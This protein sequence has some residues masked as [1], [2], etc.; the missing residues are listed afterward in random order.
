[1]SWHYTPYALLMLLAAVASLLLAFYAWRRRGTPGATML[2]LMM[3]AGATWSTAYGL[4][5]VSVGVAAKF[6]WANL[7][8]LG[9]VTV[10][11]FWMLFALLYTGRGRWVTRRA[12]ALLA[13]VPAISLALIWT[14]GAHRLFWSFRE[15]D[16]SGPFSA[17]GAVYGP[18]F[19]VHTAYCYLLILVAT[20]LLVRALVSPLRLY[21]GQRVALLIG[22][23]VPWASN[24]ASLYGL[25]PVPNLDPTPLA[26]TVTG[27][28]LSWSLLRYRFLD[29]LP[30]ARDVAVDAMQDGVIVLDAQNRVVDLNLTAQRVL[31]RTV[32]QA[33][34]GSL[35][36]IAPDLAEFL[37]RCPDAGRVSEEMGLGT[38][39]ARRHYDLTLSPLRDGSGWQAG[40]LM[41]LRD[42]TEQKRA[43]EALK[44]SEERH[45]GVLE[46]M[47]EGYFEVDLAGNLVFFNDSVCRILGYPRGE[48]IG[49]NHRDF[50]D[51]ESA[52][53]V[54]RH[55]N[56]VYRTGESVKGFDWELT[57][58]DGGR[59]YV[60]TSVS[61]RKS[62]EGEPVGFKGVIRDVSE[63]KKAETARRKS[64]ER[65]RSLVQNASDLITVVDQTGTITYESPSKERILGYGPQELVGRP[66]LEHV[67]PDDLAQVSAEF[68]SV[69]SS[70][71][72]LSEEPAE[73]WYRHA[74]GTWRYLEALAA[75]LLDDPSVGSIV[76][77]SRDVTERK[78]AEEDLKDSEERFRS[79]VQNASDIISILNPDG[80]IRY[81][82]PSVEWVLGHQP[83]ERVGR[84]AFGDET[85]PD[86]IESTRDA[87]ARGLERP[88]STSPPMGFRVRH[89]DGSWRHLEAVATNRLDH[90]AVGGIVV[91]ARD[92][93]ERKA[94]E[95]R[96][97]HQ[98]LHDG[99]TGLPNRALFLDRLSQ[100]LTRQQGRDDE[101]G[102]K[103]VA[104]LFLDLDNFKY[105]NDS[106]GHEI[107]DRMLVEAA[108]RLEGAL[109][110]P[111]TAARIGGDEFCI[112]LTEVEE[113]EEA[114][115][116]AQRV[117]EAL[118]APFVLGGREAFVPGDGLGRLERAGVERRPGQHRQRGPRQRLRVAERVEHGRTVGPVERHQPRRPV[119]GARPEHRD[120]L[121]R[122]R[123]HLRLRPG[124]RVVEGGGHDG[125][126]RPVGVGD[127]LE[128]E[129]DLLAR[130]GADGVG[131]AEVLE[132]PP[133][134]HAADA[135]EREQGEGER[136]HGGGSGRGRYESRRGRGETGSRT[137]RSGP[138]QT[139]TAFAP[140]LTRTPMPMPRP[141]RLLFVAEP[142]AAVQALASTRAGGPVQAQLAPTAD[143]LRAALAPD[144]VMAWDA[145]VFVP[146]GPVEEVE[147]AVFVPD[148][149]ALFVVGGEVPLLLSE[150]AAEAVDAAGLAGLH[151]RLAAPE[152]AVDVAPAHA[153]PAHAE[154]AHAEP[155]HAEPAHAEPAHAEPAHAGP[156][157]V[158]TPGPHSDGASGDGASGSDA[159]AV[160]VPHAPSG[161]V[162][163]DGMAGPPP[164]LAAAPPDAV[165]PETDAPAGPGAGAPDPAPRLA[166]LVDHLTV[167]LYQSG[168]DGRISYANPALA[169]IL[170]AD[171]VAALAGLDV[172][173]DLGY[174][175][176]AFVREI[177]AT[178]AVRNLVVSWVRVTGERVHTRENARAIRDDDGGL[179]YYEGTME[180]VTAEVEAQREEQAVAQQHRAAATFAAVAAE[181]TDP[182]S[183]HQA[184]AE[185]LLDATG[186]EW[187]CL[188]V[189]DGDQNRVAATAGHPPDGFAQ[190]FMASP[191]LVRHAVPSRAV[192][193]GSLSDL[194]APADVRD[195]LAEM[196]VEAAALVPVYRS[197]T[198]LGLLAWGGGRRASAADVRAAEALAWQLGG[199]LDRARAVGELRD[200]EATLS[201]IAERTPHV[202]YRLRIDPDGTAYDYLSPA[203][204]TLTGY[205]RADLDAKGGI[206]G[207]V[208]RSV[209]LE[210]EALSGLPASSDHYQARYLMATAHGPRWVED[211][212]HPWLDPSGRPVGF[213]GV[214]QDVTERKAREDR[215]ADEAQAA[216]DRQ[217]ALVD[218]SHLDGADAFGGPAAAVAAAT[219]GASDVSF[220]VC[221]PGG[222]CRALYAPPPADPSAL[223]AASLTTAARHVGEHRAL[224]ISDTASDPRL[225]DLDLGPVVR[226]FGLRSLLVAPVRRDGGV[227]GVVVV[228]HDQPHDWDAAEAEFSA[229]VADSVALALEREDRE[230]AVAAL[231][232]SQQRY[233]VLAEMTSD[234]AFA[235]VERDGRSEGVAWA[236]GACARITG[237]TLNE[238]RAPGAIVGLIHPGSTDA[239]RE[240]A[241]RWRETGEARGE[242]QIVAQS[243][244]PRWVD[245]HVRVGEPTG[246]GAVV[247]YHSGQDV[248]E[249]KAAEAALVDAREAAETGREAAE[250]MN[251]LKSSFLAN[252][253]HEIRT[254]LTGILGFADL[255]A[256]EVD[257]DQRAFVGYIERNGRRLLDTLNAVLDLSQ[258]EAGEFHAAR[259]PVPLAPAVVEAAEA[260]R[261]E[262][263]EKGVRFD[264]EADPDVVADVDPVALARVAGHLVSNA[265]KFTDA[266]GVVVSVAASGDGRAVVRVA[267]TGVGISP[268]FLP[269]AFEA[270][271]QEAT[272]HDR[273]HEGSG[274]GLT[275]VDRLVAL[276]G[277]EVAVES[278]RPGGTVVTVS[279]PRVAGSPEAPAPAPDAG[280]A[281]PSAALLG[282][283]FD[284]TFLSAPA[285]PAPSPPARPAAP[286]PPPAPTDMFDFRFGRSTPSDPSP[287]AD[288]ETPS[289]PAPAPTFAAPPAPRPPAPAAPPPVAPVASAPVAPA[290]T[291]PTPPAPTADPV[292]IVRARPDTPAPTIPQA[293]PPELAEVVDGPSDA[294]PP[295]LVVED[296]DDTRMLL[297]R[298]LRSAYDVTAVGDARSALLAMNERRFAGLVLDINL[299]GK[300]TGADVLRIARSLPDYG[301]VFAIALTAYALPG[302]RE[303]L[304]ESGFNEYISKP[305]S[306]QSLMETLAAGVHA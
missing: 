161:S 133:G 17:V 55:F 278:D 63:R 202:L 60:E 120:R 31:V 74:E 23:L 42:V 49:M 14:N 78:L 218:L 189:R 282:D 70:P 257:G 107:G 180:D 19:W 233:R 259:R 276:L 18:W 56:R 54:Y 13:V 143:A 222:P 12:L 36:G 264:V 135:V 281:R 148:G 249:R 192:S 24:A 164:A 71:G 85:H 306:R 203:I 58:K 101:D 51:Q 261:A 109:R 68:I 3:V 81:V 154:P 6:F 238:I 184:A 179:L 212:A 262:A 29:V 112:L 196:G 279:F 8:Y 67:H 171:S 130:R 160:A 52:E 140:G 277:G 10:P 141:L 73:F 188:T 253:S 97:R 229:A 66:V 168:P 273:S 136:G 131:R 255:L 217:R 11:L 280:E 134:G 106:L 292:L 205:S 125:V 61:L 223:A 50:V 283:P 116:V 272:G 251:R 234:Y 156:A 95:E 87:F 211:D 75:N 228:H 145:V 2:A 144:A 169:E 62:P 119:R 256:A 15:I 174:P 151:A 44:E 84:D 182:R 103:N 90:P 128:P 118:G 83:E 166:S 5:M 41:L 115:R 20:V 114:I 185:A 163:G 28:A 224:A 286:T 186:A 176:D 40:S 247:V 65:F 46:Q 293:P 150:T 132:Q 129:Q 236:T 216:L 295:I 167:G 271:R 124:Q 301:G 94:Y 34:G 303:R 47:E 27:V 214:L 227:V 142:A 297:E 305:F 225:A 33:V 248:T 110:P 219:L 240:L 82:S 111:D 195:A 64:E 72:Y 138:G 32:P 69:L 265:V 153:E 157:P 268:A 43:E 155:A 284:F 181:S 162:P 302:D 149:L 7:K 250:R 230:R 269:D 299:G 173:E 117:S 209:I 30:V 289:A 296:N 254:P 287:P 183:I 158:P 76:I 147:V 239:V 178:D 220:W 127:P 121:G 99:L 207:I 187:T 193:V 252:M 175:R 79:L 204:E 226:A 35:T 100:A 231:D 126:D 159:P 266:G 260:F 221:E 244:Q 45:R 98:A 22:V 246:D 37:E 48:L 146:G 294:R 213:V 123:L 198:P 206:K 38:G 89:E 113:E 201:V 57:K 122:Q 194:D 210:G 243:G 91:N 93:T 77:T 102:E 88:G 263:A 197:G 21:R 172:Q 298:I 274:L 104:V 291:A 177:E 139:G 270:F 208:E 285:D 39:D 237:Y 190:T 191:G 25:N 4:E 80:T 170:G 1:M 300:E 258:L 232:V 241:R 245:H 304:L 16:T 26:F 9:I 267:D 215:L 242:V 96:L 105:V 288:A 108:R 235:V 199:H 165:P 86:D 92:V 59:L 152:A 137:A 275:V 53:E 290:P 200:S